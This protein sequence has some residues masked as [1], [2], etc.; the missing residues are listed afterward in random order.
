MRDLIA[1]LIMP[2][3][4]LFLIMGIGFYLAWRQ[5][6]AGLLV[7]GAASLAFFLLCLPVTAAGLMSLAQAGVKPLST[8]DARTSGAEAVVVLSAGLMAQ[9]PQFNGRPDVDAVSL[10][11]LRYGAFLARQGDL[12]VLVSGGQWG[13][14]RHVLSVVM[15]QSLRTDFGL[16]EIWQEGTSQN[17]RENARNSAALLSEK[18][19]TRILLVTHAWH[20]RRAARAFERAGLEVVEAPLSFEGKGRLRLRSFLPTSK[21]LHTSTWAIHELI[22]RAWYALTA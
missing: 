8:Q 19:V 13:P 11:R 4:S 6:R 18:G 3:F 15:A 21:S 10:E 1:F 14:Q 5:H 12:P 16:T 2:P 22:G 17:T 20:M 7:L 9:S